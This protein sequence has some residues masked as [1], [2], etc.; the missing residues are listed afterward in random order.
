LF[1]TIIAGT[2][3]ILVDQATKHVAFNMQ[4]EVVNLTS[5]LTIHKVLNRGAA[6]GFLGQTENSN[7]ILILLSIVTIASLAILIK[8][9]KKLSLLGKIPFG[10]IIGGALSNLFDR[11]YYGYVKDFIYFHYN[12]FS[13]PT[14]NF[15]D[16][17]ICIGVLL[18][19]ITFLRPHADKEAST[20]P[21]E[22]TTAQAV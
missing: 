15:A 2:L 3:A 14:F 13:W 19:L 16:V 5:F 20:A 21:S 10:L 17:F 7:L 22:D 9:H 4:A 12:R 6:F 18:L 1:L 8:N 11:I